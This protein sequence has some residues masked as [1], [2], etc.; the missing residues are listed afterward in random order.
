ME[1]R[2]A[3]IPSRTSAGV[4]GELL[5]LTALLLCFTATSAS[6]GT[7][8]V[9]ASGDCV[10]AGGHATIQAGVDAASPGDTIQVGPGTYAENVIIRKALKVIGDGVVPGTLDLDSH[11]EPPAIVDGGQNGS[12]FQVSCSSCQV[13]LK[14]LRIQN[15]VAQDGGGVYSANA[16]LQL[17]KVLLEQNEASG[18]GGGVYSTGPLLVLNS[19]VHSNRAYFGGGLHSQADITVK[20]SKIGTNFGTHGGGIYVVAGRSL[21]FTKGRVFGNYSPEGPGGISMTANST[22]TLEDVSFLGNGGRGAGAMTANG[23]LNITNCTFKGNFTGDDGPVEQRYAG[24]IRFLGTATATITNTTIFHNRGTRTGGL[25]VLPG[26][27]VTLG[28]TILAG[29]EALGGLPGLLCPADT[30]PDAPDG[31]ECDDCRLQSSARITSAGYNLAG[32]GSCALDAPSDLNDVD[33]KLPDPEGGEGYWHFPLLPGSPAIDSGS[34]VTTADALGTA[35]P[36]G[37]GCDR[38]ATEQ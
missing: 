1:V 8:V 12:V 7:I 13:N 18:R 21:T 4:S 24:A 10:E 32:D 34:C 11:L 33:P 23:S 2:G 26:A 3:I 5:I 36:A 22:V 9:C 6:A 29:N 28:N 15:G 37:G 31:P 25:Y 19:E 17:R 16:N 27:S 30:N 20:N 38:G 14:N 35:R